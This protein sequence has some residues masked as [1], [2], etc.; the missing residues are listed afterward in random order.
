[1][2]KPIYTWWD[3]EF[4]GAGRLIRLDVRAA[5]HEIWDEASR[6]THAVLADRG[7][8][9]DLMER[10]VAQISRY[11]DRI[12]AP[13]ARP[14][15]GLLMVAFCRALRRHAS[16]LHRL[17]FVGGSSELA[18][19]TLDELWVRQVHARL[20]I[21]R[22]ISRLSEKNGQVLSLR[23]AGFEWPEIAQLFGMS[24]A[25]VRGGF[26]REIRRIRRQD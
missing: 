18:R 3:R 21:E 1:M 14:K 12:G 19:R 13:P 4:D 2:A 15:R 25:A 23:A 8:A 17:R 26:W 11:L 6:R 5:A 10:S 24:V 9:A 16:K 20:D 22:T 7:P